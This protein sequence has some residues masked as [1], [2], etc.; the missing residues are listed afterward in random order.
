MQVIGAIGYVDKYGFVINLAK[1]LRMCG[2]SVIVIDGTSDRKYRYVI[3]SLTFGDKYYIT[4]YDGIDFAVGFDS[5]HDLENYTSEQKI[6]I[7]LYDYM[8]IDIDNSKA[9]EFFRTRGID[10]HYFFIDTSVISLAKNMDILKTMK[11]YSTSGDSLVLTKVL[12][13]AYLTR[14]QEQYFFK[15]MQEIDAKWSTT[16]Y[17]IPNEEQDKMA[18]IDAQISGI[19]DIRKHTKTYIQTIADIVAELLGD[20]SSRNIYKTIKRRKF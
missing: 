3:P 10:K 6:N 8:I 13:R 7:S 16:E 18:D 1:T 15:K 12:F 4:Q 19:I 20:T 17:E 9:Y 14:A 11:V 2:K 5:M